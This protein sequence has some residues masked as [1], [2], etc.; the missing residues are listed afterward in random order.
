MYSVVKALDYKMLWVYGIGLQFVLWHRNKI[1][2][3]VLE[4]NYIKKHIILLSTLFCV[5]F[6]GGLCKLTY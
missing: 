6:W 1:I 3:M 4:Y 5:V 2:F